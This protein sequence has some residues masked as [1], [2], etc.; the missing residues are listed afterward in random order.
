MMFYLN[1]EHGARFLQNAALTTPWYMTFRC[2]AMGEKELTKNNNRVAVIRTCKR[3]TLLPNTTT[4]VS[5]YYDKEIPY[6]TTPSIIQSTILA[7]DYK[8]IDTEPTVRNYQY[9]KMEH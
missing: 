5:G 7:E 8:E 2:L 3:I 1:E 4:E 9:K 6:K